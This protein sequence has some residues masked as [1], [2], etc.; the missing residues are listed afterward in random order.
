MSEL[1]TIPGLDQSFLELLEAAGFRDFKDLAEADDQDLAHELERANRI[2]KIAKS[3][4]DHNTVAAWVRQA[5]EHTGM[6]VEEPVIESVNHEKDGKVVAMLRSS[7]LAIPLPGNALKDKGLSVPDIPSGLLLNEYPGD[8]DI[9]VDK[10]IPNA[11]TDASSHAPYIQVS[12]KV[13]QSKLDIDVSRLKSMSHLGPMRARAHASPEPEMEDRIALIRAPKASTNEGRDPNSRRYIRG[14]L[15]SH[16]GGIYIGAFLTVVL[17]FLAP[18]A[19][20]A[21]LVLLLSREMP[22]SFGWVEEW[23][24][25][26][27][28]AL[29]VVALGWAIW[30]LSGKCRVCGQRLFIHRPHRK[31]AKAH[32]IAGFGYVL[33]LCVHILLF[34]WFRC[35]HCGTPVRLKK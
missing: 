10:R 34:R 17:M 3:A 21:A 2:L 16:P 15:H 6:T 35:S 31:N 22:A 25:A 33:P 1:L 14:V 9:R 24:L 5:R 32:H 8:L 26:F 12:E 30:G 27:P 7:P 23:W 11:R 19:V 13:S 18:L 29:P 4:P 20:V 28:V